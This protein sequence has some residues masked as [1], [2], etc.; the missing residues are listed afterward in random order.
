MKKTQVNKT[1]KTAIEN[2]Q[3]REQVVLKKTFIPGQRTSVLNTPDFL[4]YLLV[5]RDFACFV[6]FLRQTG[7]WHDSVVHQ[8]DCSYRETPAAHRAMPGQG[9]RQDTLPSKPSRPQPPQEE[10]APGTLLNPR[11]FENLHVGRAAESKPARRMSC[12]LKTCRQDELQPALTQL[13]TVTH[14]Y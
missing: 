6:S 14:H 9:A 5:Q 1:Q 12:R 10:Q 4:E 3:N 7:T 13:Y 2:K 8:K 11:D